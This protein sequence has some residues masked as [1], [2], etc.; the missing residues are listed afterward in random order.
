VRVFRGTSFKTVNKTG[1]VSLG[2]IRF[3]RRTQPTATTDEE[4]LTDV[5]KD[6]EAG[7][8]LP[9]GQAASSVFQKDKS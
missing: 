3:T 4:G 5:S 8:A 9:I 7:R 2:T 1:G 6:A